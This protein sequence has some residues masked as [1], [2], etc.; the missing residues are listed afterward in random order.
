MQYQFITENSHRFDVAE[1]CECFDLSRSGYY[2]WK[3]R[4]R[5]QRA[6]EDAAHKSRI[7]ELCRQAKGRYGHRP[8]YHHLA[9][10]GIRCGR[11]RTLRLMKEL[12]I[13]GIQKKAFKPLVTDSKHGFGYSPNL[14]KELGQPERCDQVW[15][16]DTT[17]L[18]SEEGWCYL[19][20]VMDLYSRRVIGWSVSKRNDS[21]LVCEA[22]RGAILTRGAKVS[23]DLMHHSDRGSTYA[24][25]PYTR[26]LGAFKIKQSMSA[27]GNCYDNAAME[28]FY[29]RYKTSSVR[30]NV[31]EGEEQ[32][33]INAFEYIEVFYNRFRK[34]ASLGYQSPA[35]F[36]AK[37][38]PPMGGEESAS[39]AACQNNN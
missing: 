29:G 35:K 15:V 8:I 6:E 19:A 36:E 38:S 33:R 23:P 16:S 31:F 7:S 32:A 25:G 20:T 4:G 24:S 26:L 17:Y 2:D 27:K 10:E 39:L 1:M 18:R 37:N 12:G 13:E 22:L 9:E 21:S 5:S 3:G 11:D 28:S 14:L 30:G 34:H